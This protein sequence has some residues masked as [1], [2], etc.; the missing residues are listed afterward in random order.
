LIDYSL[1]NYSLNAIEYLLLMINQP[2]K[3][4]D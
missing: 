4:N 1:I 3:T 2:I